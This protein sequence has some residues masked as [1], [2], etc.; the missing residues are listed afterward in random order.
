MSNDEHGKR[1]PSLGSKFLTG[2]WW[3]LTEIL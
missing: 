3:M 2:T 1:R